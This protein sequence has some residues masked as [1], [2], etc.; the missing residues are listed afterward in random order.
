MYHI[1]DKTGAKTLIGSGFAG[2]Y[3]GA[4]NVAMQCVKDRGP[5]PAGTYDMKNVATSDYGPNGIQLKARTADGKICGRSQFW[6]HAGIGASNGCIDL[7]ASSALAQIA[8][9][10]RGGDTELRVIG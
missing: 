10:V 3:D 1:D 6:I 8:A 2:N 5:L 4:N 9:G 7:S